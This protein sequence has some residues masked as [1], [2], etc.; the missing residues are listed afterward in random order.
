MTLQQDHGDAPGC[1]LFGIVLSNK[2][3]R[4]HLAQRYHYH[5][6]AGK[7]FCIHEVLLEPIDKM[8]D[9]SYDW[10][11]KNVTIHQGSLF[12]SG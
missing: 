10:G 2:M 6:P 12:C 8:E 11:W 5:P 3:H 4:V 7:M 1:S 9:N